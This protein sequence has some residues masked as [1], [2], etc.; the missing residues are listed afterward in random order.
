M[1]R[2]TW[3]IV[4]LGFAVVALIVGVRVFRKSGPE[5]H[6]IGAI[7]FLTGPQAPLG[8]EVKNALTVGVDEI[9][10][11]GGIKGKRVEV[12]YEDSKDSPRDAILA[13]SRLETEKVPVMICTGDVV[14]LNLAPTVEEKRIP[15]IATVAA[16]PDISKKSDWVFRVFI[17]ASRQ[18]ST[19]A[20]YSSKTLGLTS[21]AILAIN[22]EFGTT[23]TETFKN[24]FERNGGRITKSET[25][26]VA[27]RDVRAQITKLKGT[28]PQ[29]IYVSGFGDG[30]GAAVKQV[31]ELGFAGQLLSDATLSIPYFLQ[32]TSPANEGAYFTSTMYDEG[33]KAPLA[34]NFIR[35]YKE[36]FGS[37]PGF[38]GAFAYDA[39]R[40]IANAIEIAGDNPQGIKDA[41]MST[42]DFQGVVGKVSFANGNDL[43]FPLVIKRMEKGKAVIVWGGE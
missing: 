19:M 38:V 28:N 1:K 3:V 30:Y 5:V 32:Q 40:L 20:E 18:A 2:N 29:A 4:G 34:A 17:Q 13:F 11:K 12:L 15:T 43:D 35:R 22:N 14:S 33:S 10:E 27:D 36:K 37:E 42:R 31:R 39:F 6:K 25:F 24:V 8:T 26:D 16:G 21:A 7:V 9:N 41:L 23:T